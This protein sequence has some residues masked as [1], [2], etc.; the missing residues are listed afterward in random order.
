MREIHV[1]APSSLEYY[2]SVQV[3]VEQARCNPGAYRLP[4]FTGDL[5]DVGLKGDNFHPP[6]T[7][8]GESVLIDPAR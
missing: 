8:G 7:D 1:S 6:T 4:R 3:L 2:L 5:S